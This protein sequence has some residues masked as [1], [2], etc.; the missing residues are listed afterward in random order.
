MNVLWCDRFVVSIFFEE[1]FE[2]GDDSAV[3]C[4]EEV[5]SILVEGAMSEIGSLDD[6]KSRRDEALSMH[7]GGT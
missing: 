2:I 5:F 1:G 7:V 4:D 3:M 6:S